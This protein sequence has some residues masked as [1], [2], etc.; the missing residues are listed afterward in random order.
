MGY[1][2]TCI[3]LT[4]HTN[5]TI[6]IAITS[7]HLHFRILYS[8]ILVISMLNTVVRTALLTNLT[9]VHVAVHVIVNWRMT[10]VS[11]LHASVA[12]KKKLNYIDHY[13]IFCLILAQWYYTTNVGVKTQPVAKRLHWLELS[14]I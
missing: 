9:Y 4:G 1:V 10:D 7:K 3:S 14:Y 13:T 8:V 5:K 2:Y 6:T 12:G 11:D